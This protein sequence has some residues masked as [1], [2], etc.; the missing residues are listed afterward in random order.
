MTRPKFKDNHMD[1][2]PNNSNPST[3]VVAFLPLFL[4]NMYLLLPNYYC[5]ISIPYGVLAAVFMAS[6]Y[7]I[8]YNY[9]HNL[10]SFTLLFQ[11]CLRSLKFLHL[12]QAISVVM[13]W[14][15]LF[16]SSSS[17]PKSDASV[18]TP[19]LPWPLNSSEWLTVLGFVLLCQGVCFALLCFTGSPYARHKQDSNLGDG[20]QYL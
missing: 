9:V 2:W 13:S 5:Y 4:S 19:L 17:D 20:F 12:F 16:Y 11:S 10:F 6:P 14:P 1:S 15:W 18:A 7:C 3:Y 8:L